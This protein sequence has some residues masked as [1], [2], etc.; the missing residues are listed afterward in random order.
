MTKAKRAV[1]PNS[2]KFRNA[3][4]R[5]MASF[6]QVLRTSRTK[7]KPRSVTACVNRWTG[8]PHEHKH[9]IARSTRRASRHGN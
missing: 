1:K 6:F 2:R 4:E 7:P 5:L 3:A 9:E 8:K